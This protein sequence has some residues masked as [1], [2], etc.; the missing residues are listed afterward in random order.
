MGNR[1][2]KR[3][4]ETGEVMGV[5]EN[6]D[7]DVNKI[8]GEPYICVYEANKPRVARKDDELV[9]ISLAGNLKAY[10]RFTVSQEMQDTLK[11]I[12]GVVNMRGSIVA[13]KRILENFK[14]KQDDVIARALVNMQ[15]WGVE[16]VPLRE[17]IARMTGHACLPNIP[18]YVVRANEEIVP[19]HGAGV[20]GLNCLLDRVRAQIGDD[21]YIIPCSI[22]EL[23]CISKSFNGP[24]IDEMREMVGVVNATEVRDEDKL[25]DDVFFYDENGLHVALA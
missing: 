8:L 14:L 6:V 11:D 1:I 9:E 18:V 20:L 13:T 24:K 3:N 16:V 19:D 12:D 17:M 22:H 2:E 5:F 7:I 15:E 4:R 25:S 23:I 21:F 10:I